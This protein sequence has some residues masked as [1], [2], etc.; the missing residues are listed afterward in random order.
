[1]L[2]S[3]RDT[4]MR[5]VTQRQLI[6]AA[7]VFFVICTLYFAAGP[8]RGTGRWDVSPSLLGSDTPPEVWKARAE[9]V[10]QAFRHAYGGYERHAIPHDELRPLTNLT[11]DNFN[12]WGVTLF[13]SL[14]TMILMGLNDEFARALPIVEQADFIPS[15]HV[16]NSHRGYAPFFETVIRYL[17]GLLSAYALSREPLL[18]QRA[19]DLGRLLSPAFNTPSGFPAFGVNTANGETVGPTVGI[20]AE[21]ASCQ[22]EY[23]YLA[24][25]TGKKAHFDKAEGV[26]NNLRR[27][28]V[29]TRGGMFP[30][31]W[32]LQ[33]GRPT[34]DVLSV[35]AAADSAHEYLLKMYLMTAQ[36]DKSSYEMYIRTTNHILTNLMYLTD[37]RELLYVTDVA[38]PTFS[39]SH[40]FEHLSC[41]LPGL[42]A[43]GADQLDLSLDVLDPRTLGDEERRSYELL[44][45]YDLRQ[46]HRWA[47]EGLTT[48]CYL[49][50]ADQ[51]SGLAPD[52]V[53]MQPAPGFP[54]RGRQR[55][56]VGGKR[57]IDAMEEWRKYGRRGAPPGVGDRR[58]VQF[59]DQ[60]QKN[61]KLRSARTNERGYSLKRTDYLLRPETLESIYLMYRTTGDPVWR[62]RGWQIFEA[63]ERECKTPSGYASIENVLRSPAPQADDMPSYFLAETLKYLYLMFHE[64]DLVPLDRW[65]FNTE[66]HP[67]PVFTWSAWERSKFGI[68]EPSS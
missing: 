14:D 20:L 24:L 27:A 10:K 19:D 67:L 34:D 29:S 62:E 54:P 28:N 36:S 61:M 55:N 66:A 18:L 52:E 7:V 43:L 26:M 37:A 39:P 1:M 2:T 60:E 58:P 38:T 41:F 8:S 31:R 4:L 25:A 17:G 42:L 21:I 46:L 13:D 59:T 12:G 56:R 22:M 6:Y 44:K 15:P 32:S 53:Q 23:T 45:H 30:R 11:K 35:G 63:L 47:A 33:S 65:V 40:R 9:Q 5:R 68:P 48:A 49:M 57:W 51:P 16:T 50:Y 64:R 3:V